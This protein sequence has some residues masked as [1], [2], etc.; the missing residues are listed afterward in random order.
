MVTLTF[1]RI[2]GEINYDDKEFYLDTE[3]EEP[4]SLEFQCL[5]K[6]LNAPIRITLGTG[7]TLNEKVQDFEHILSLST[8]ENYFVSD[9]LLKQII[10]LVFLPFSAKNSEKKMPLSLYY[11]FK[12]KTLSSF[13]LKENKE[14]SLM[15]INEPLNLEG[16]YS[17]SQDPFSIH[18]K[19]KLEAKAKWTSKSPYCESL[20]LSHTLIEGKTETLFENPLSF[21]Y[22]VS[23]NLKK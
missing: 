23:L 3:K 21:D 2:Q 6:L 7:I 12:A 20:S 13:E 4:I 19:G 17:T 9:D 1:R 5:K 14:E 8:L 11:P 18:L 15:L 10:E 22:A 16:L